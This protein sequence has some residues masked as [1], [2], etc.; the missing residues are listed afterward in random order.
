MFFAVYLLYGLAC[1]FIV[2]AR[3]VFELLRLILLTV[4]TVTVV[5]VMIVKRVYQRHQA[6]KNN[7]APDKRGR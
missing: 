3:V 1:F 7:S 2:L 5:V 6:R 4:V